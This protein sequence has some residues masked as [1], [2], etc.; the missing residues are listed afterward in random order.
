M[1]R[2]SRAAA[3]CGECDDQSRLLS[4]SVFQSH[5]KATELPDS[6]VGAIHKIQ[7]DPGRMTK[8]HLENC[9]DNGFSVERYVEMVSVVATSVIIDTMHKALSLPIPEVVDIHEGEPLGQEKPTVVDAGAWVPIAPA[10]PELNEIGI[11]RA[12][13]IVRSMGAVPSA[14]LM[15][16][17]V[18]RSH[19]M[20]TDLP[21]EIERSQAELAAARVSLLNQCFY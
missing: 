20:V 4:S 2:E 7:S 17:T 14:V 8:R 9:V 3:S 21:V 1:V 11:P 5:S 6:I 10:D 12:A 16:F 19:Y 18:F 13:N 15:F